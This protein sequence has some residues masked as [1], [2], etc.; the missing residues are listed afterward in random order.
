MLQV[1][2]ILLMNRFEQSNVLYSTLH[3]VHHQLYSYTEYNNRTTQNIITNKI[4]YYKN[5]LS[6]R[7]VG[8]QLVQVDI[9]M[10]EPKNGK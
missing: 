7:V 4:N 1:N 6:S 5:N 3:Q 9:S 8:L 10:I 2:F